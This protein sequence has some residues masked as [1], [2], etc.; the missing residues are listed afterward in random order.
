MAIFCVSAHRP[1]RLAES[2]NTDVAFIKQL[3]FR[4][5]EVLNMLVMLV[6]ELFETDKRNLQ[7]TR[8]R[9]LI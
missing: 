1:R 6:G 2:T 3:K 4:M 9:V 7:M 5:N 8:V